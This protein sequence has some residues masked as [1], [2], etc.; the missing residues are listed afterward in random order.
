M[1]CYRRQPSSWRSGMSTNSDEKRTAKAEVAAEKARAK[2]QR[3]WYQKKRVIIP[4]GLIALIIIV[5]VANG[6]FD[7]AAVELQALLNDRREALGEDHPETERSF[8]LWRQA[9]SSVGDDRLC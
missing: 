4:L 6:D 3:S 8:I 1:Y 5:A 9:E 7:H 2:A